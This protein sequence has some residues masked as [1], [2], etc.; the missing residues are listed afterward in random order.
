MC[1]SKKELS[2]VRSAPVHLEFKVMM[3]GEIKPSGT[4]IISSY[5][6]DY[7]LRTIQPARHSQANPCDSSITFTTSSDFKAW[8]F[9]LHAQS[10]WIHTICTVSLK[11]CVLSCL[12]QWHTTSRPL[13]F[14]QVSTINLQ[15]RHHIQAEETCQPKSKCWNKDE[16]YSG[17]TTTVIVRVHARLSKG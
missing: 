14:I 10:T 12:E 2:G 16:K 13:F 9:Q 17:S 7:Y 8:V 3:K 1:L 5:L 4:I 6:T 11:A 15:K